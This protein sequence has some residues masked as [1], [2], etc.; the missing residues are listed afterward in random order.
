[1]APGGQ[2]L[3]FRR[4][5]VGLSLAKVEDKILQRNFGLHNSG[6]DHDVAARGKRFW[7]RLDHS[8]IC[9]CCDPRQ[10]RIVGAF[11]NAE[12][13]R[14]LLGALPNH[15][16]AWIVVFRNIDQLR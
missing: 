12:L 9:E 7:K 15:A 16:R 13:F 8:F 3:G 6:F 1:M 4:A 5:D 10:N 14:L 2:R 11:R